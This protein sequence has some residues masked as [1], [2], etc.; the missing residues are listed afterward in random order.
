VSPADAPASWL[1]TLLPATV[2]LDAAPPEFAEPFPFDLDRWPAILADCVLSDGRH[3]V[4]GDD[5][6]PHHVW[7][8]HVS[9][10]RSLAY[11]IVRDDAIETRRRAAQRLDRRLGGAPPSQQGGAFRP[12]PF[13]RRRLNLLLDILDLTQTPDERP[14]SYEIARR[15]IYRNA[16]IGRGQEWKSSTERRRT[17]R[18]IGQ[19][20][21]LMTGDYRSLLRGVVKG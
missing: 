8:R 7:Q 10:S 16:T 14:T 2:V 1:A 21:R 4:L 6:G 12:T 19:A 5:G 17:L 3:M 13:Q 11:I 9:R 20:R 15:L 18:L